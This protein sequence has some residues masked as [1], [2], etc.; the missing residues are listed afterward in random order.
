M[1]TSREV[2]PQGLALAL[3]LLEG[4]KLREI[5]PSDY[6]AHLC[7]RPEY[8]NVKAAIAV[9]T[10]ISLWI[11]QSLLHYDDISPRASVWTFFIHTAD[12]RYPH[13]LATPSFSPH[14]LTLLTGVPETS[15]L[16]KPHYNCNSTWFYPGAAFG[17]HKELS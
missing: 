15:K 3:T 10:K 9:N 12:V 11:K 17:F 16:S 4:D 13:V 1:L 14:L 5:T 6:L 2:S 7:G 8:T